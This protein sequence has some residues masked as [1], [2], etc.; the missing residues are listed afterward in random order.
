MPEDHT[1]GRLSRGRKGVRGRRGGRESEREKRMNLGLYI[2]LG[3][4]AR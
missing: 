3:L 4:R 2:Y 1:R